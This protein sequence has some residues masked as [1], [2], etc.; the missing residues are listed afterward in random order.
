MKESPKEI[1]KSYNLCLYIDD[2]KRV[3]AAMMKMAEMAFNGARENWE[4]NEQFIP[5][6]EDFKDWFDN[7]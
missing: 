7:C 5:K 1:M 2:E 3:I 6:Y 4:E